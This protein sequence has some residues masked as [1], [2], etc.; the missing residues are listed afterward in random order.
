LADGLLRFLAAACGKRTMSKYVALFSPLLMVSSVW[1]GGCY[2]QAGSLP[3]AQPVV[4]AAPP[5]DPP[6]A[7]E[8]EPVVEAAPEYY[9][10][11]PHFYPLALGGD[12]CPIAEPHV[13]D[14]PPDHPEYYAYDSGYYYYAGRPGEVYVVG[15]TPRGARVHVVHEG[16]A[17]EWRRLPPTAARPRLVDGRYPAREG[18]PAPVHP[19]A[20]RGAPESHAAVEHRIEPTHAESPIAGR[21][22]QHAARPVES[23]ATPERSRAQEE[24]QSAQEERGKEERP[25]T[26]ASVGASAR[27][28][29]EP[30]ARSQVAARSI[31]PPK[32]A[33]KSAPK[34]KNEKKK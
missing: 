23:P 29:S 34:P 30:A 17:H 13:H 33:I 11:G 31:S 32:A 12:W 2:V 25:A 16:D 10:G 5:P 20:Q 1:L 15:R 28:S 22:G 8:A 19:I 4:Y 18:H 9:Y 21:D 27:A 24:A 7:V 6:P 14:F 26:P 3:P